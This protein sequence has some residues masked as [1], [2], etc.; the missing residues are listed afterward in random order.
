M[1]QTE[2]G[3]K[4]IPLPGGKRAYIF[5]GCLSGMLLLPEKSPDFLKA[6]RSAMYTAVDAAAEVTALMEVEAMFHAR[7]SSAAGLPRMIRL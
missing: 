7:V 6:G 4:D 1:G 3:G 5:R 2:A